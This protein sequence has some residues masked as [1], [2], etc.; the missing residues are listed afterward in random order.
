MIIRSGSLSNRSAS[1][2]GSRAR[3]PQ[4]ASL[5][6]ADVDRGC[7]EAGDEV[8]NLYFANRRVNQPGTGVSASGSNGRDFLR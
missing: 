6:K 3:S 5:R 8:Y 4:E 1:A 2:S 7:G